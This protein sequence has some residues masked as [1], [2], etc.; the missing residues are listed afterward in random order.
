MNTNYTTELL[1][2]ACHGDYR[3]NL[4]VQQSLDLELFPEA[5]CYT[6]K[7]ELR[8]E[9]ACGNRIL[10]LSFKEK[11]LFAVICT[12]WHLYVYSVEENCLDT[13]LIINRFASHS[14]IEGLS[15]I[16][17]RS[18]LAIAL[19]KVLDEE[20]HSLPELQ[21]RETTAASGGLCGIAAT[22][23]ALHD[24][25]LTPSQL[26]KMNHIT[27]KEKILTELG[28]DLVL[29]KKELDL[30]VLRMFHGKMCNKHISE[31]YEFPNLI[32]KKKREISYDESEKSLS[33]S[34]TNKARY[35]RDDADKEM[36]FYGN[37]L[38]YE[39][40]LARRFE[41]GETGRLYDERSIVCNW[42]KTWTPYNEL[43][44]CKWVACINPP[45]PPSFTNLKVEWDGI[46]V[47]FTDNIPYTCNSD[48]VNHYFEWDRDMEH[49]NVTCLSIALKFENHLYLSRNIYR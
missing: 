2:S 36:T 1:K 12:P 43:D 30:T 47:N 39:C 18:L 35:K 40:G 9:Y 5:D 3:C 6:P 32:S 4:E 33:I 26:K 45:D 37:K 34:I 13:S 19:N 8:V 22:F 25:F 15:D 41:D 16:D 7:Q 20:E 23:Q 21:S 17:K 10:L 14:D 38:T 44:S 29:A 27:M 31:E 48:E 49:Y 28:M 24:T 46:P 11:I 42:N